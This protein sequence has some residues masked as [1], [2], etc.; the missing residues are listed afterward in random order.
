MS[1][2]T[3][4]PPPIDDSH[5]AQQLQPNNEALSFTAPK[6]YLPGFLLSKVPPSLAI[7]PRLRANLKNFS[8]PGT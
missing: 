5:A 4:A 8:I 2:A 3:A 1:E 7:H 6:Q